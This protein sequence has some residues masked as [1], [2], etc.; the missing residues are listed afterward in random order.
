MPKTALTTGDVARHCQ[1][2]SETVSNWIRTGKLEA[3]ATP[4]NHRRVRLEDFTA[5][6][7]FHDMPPYASRKESFTPTTP[8]NRRL[9]VVDDDR[10]HG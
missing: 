8:A 10:V 2:S 7:A 5:F 9:L 3:Y 6:L 4:G 1:V